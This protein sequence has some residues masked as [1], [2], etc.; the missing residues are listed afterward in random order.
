MQKWDDNMVVLEEENKSLEDAIRGLRE[1]IDKLKKRQ[2]Q[3]KIK[4][5]KDE[6]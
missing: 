6:L 4:T 5:E 2:E 3:K 1:I